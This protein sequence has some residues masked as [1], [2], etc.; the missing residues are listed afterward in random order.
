MDSD[1]FL[2]DLFV[3]DHN[4]QSIGDDESIKSD[5]FVVFDN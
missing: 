4:T 1:F 3:D 5:L 2:A